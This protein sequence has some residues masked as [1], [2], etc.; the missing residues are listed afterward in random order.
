MLVYTSI[1]KSYLPKARVLG[2]SLKRHNPDWRLCVILCDTP[3][4][5]FDVSAEPFDE[6]VT[7][8]QLGLPNWK[9]WAFGHDVVELC[10]GVK[11]AAA[12][13]LADRDG[14]DR[15][16]YLD[17]DI[18]VCAPLQPL[19]ELLDHHEIVLT[20]H[21]LDPESDP[22][23]VVDN[24]ICVLRH[25][26]FNLGFLGVR[27]KGQGRRFIDWWSARLERHCLADPQNGLFTDQKWV[28]LAPA[29]FDG[30]YVVRDKGC[31]VATWNIHRRPIRRN[32]DGLLEAG[33]ARLRFYHFTGYDSGD[34]RGMLLKYAGQQIEALEL[35]DAYGR[36]LAANGHRDPA[37]DHFA[38]G[39]FS[40]GAPIDKRLRRLYRARPDLQEAFPDPFEVR[41]WSLYN[42][43]REEQRS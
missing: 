16:I 21:L 29:F 43:W 6:L 30:V 34:G 5:G 22:Q 25:G 35:W 18:L 15:L 40:N 23:A 42:W 13:L 26:V 39:F 10:T 2:R 12:K 4:A 33:G 24:E 31:N 7:L 1:T 19:A 14:E 3:P 32:G 11:G 41:K 37:L 28:D 38:Y 27:M 20:P 8:D 17:P 36:E 9:A